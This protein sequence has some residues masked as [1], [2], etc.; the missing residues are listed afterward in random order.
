MTIH[1]QI[2]DRIIIFYSIYF[3]FRNELVTA[4]VLDRGVLGTALDLLV[5]SEEY[6]LSNIGRRNISYNILRFGYTR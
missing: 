2:K 6:A 1:C 5:E 3:N 4:I